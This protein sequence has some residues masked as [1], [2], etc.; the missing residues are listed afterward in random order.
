MRKY[1]GFAT[2][3][4]IGLKKELQINRSP[5]NLVSKKIDL[6]RENFRELNNHVSFAYVS[7]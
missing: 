1:I 2:V 7:S 6:S 5:I 4:M 3:Q